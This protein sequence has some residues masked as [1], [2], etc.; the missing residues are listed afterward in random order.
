MASLHIEFVEKFLEQEGIEF[1]IE[2]DCLAADLAKLSAISLPWI[3]M[4]CDLDTKSHLKHCSLCKV[5]LLAVEC[6]E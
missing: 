6:P 5:I 4:A 2:T 3:P 1:G